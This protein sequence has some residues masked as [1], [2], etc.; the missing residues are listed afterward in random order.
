MTKEVT[1]RYSVNTIGCVMKGFKFA[2]QENMS[3]NK[4]LT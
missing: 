1:G 3:A 2:K 4:R